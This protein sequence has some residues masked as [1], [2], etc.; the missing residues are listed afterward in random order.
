[1]NNKKKLLQEQ[2]GS[3]CNGQVVRII[4]SMTII[5][6]AG[7]GQLD[8]DDKV[9]VYH[10]GEEI[11]DLDGSSLGNYEYIKELFKV[12]QVERKYSICQTIAFVESPLATLATSPLLEKKKVPMK[13]D[14]QEIMPLEHYDERIHVGDPV[15][16]P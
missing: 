1:M 14:K 8:V 11:K 2:Y 16:R 15:K 9:Q 6:N 12:I 13:L 10:H 4:D 5:I 3:S 7:V